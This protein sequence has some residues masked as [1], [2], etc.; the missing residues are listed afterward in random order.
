MVGILAFVSLLFADGRATQS[1]LHSR[2]I[3]KI[4][5]TLIGVRSR[6]CVDNRGP[7]SQ[8]CANRPDRCSRLCVTGAFRSVVISTRCSRFCVDNFA[9]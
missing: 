1:W 2:P 5:Q 4:Y 7:R 8:L 9:V 6:L 3:G